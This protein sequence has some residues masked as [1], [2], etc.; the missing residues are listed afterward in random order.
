LLETQAINNSYIGT[1][2]N[3]TTSSLLYEWYANNS[4]ISRA[5]GPVNFKLPNNSNTIDANYTIKLVV[6]ENINNCK[7]SSSIGNLIVYPKPKAI[8]TIDKGDTT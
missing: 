5:A 3:R 8:F 1:N 4:L 7:D 6:T 2:T